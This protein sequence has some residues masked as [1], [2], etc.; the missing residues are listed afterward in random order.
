MD[1]TLIKMGH[2][3]CAELLSGQSRDGVR[4]QITAHMPDWA[5]SDGS[6]LISAAV[7]V[8]CPGTG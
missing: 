2:L 5:D 8:Y 3:V 7:G 4:D 6:A 1:Q